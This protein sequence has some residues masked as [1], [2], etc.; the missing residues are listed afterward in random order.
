[1]IFLSGPHLLRVS[2]KMFIA[3]F[4][5][6][7]LNAFYAL[8][9]NSYLT[10]LIILGKEQKLGNLLLPTFFCRTVAPFVL[11]S[12]VLFTKICVLVDG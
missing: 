4:P 6:S 12:S 5:C 2:T 1:M 10:I 7:A 8:S 9:I 3:I 11:V